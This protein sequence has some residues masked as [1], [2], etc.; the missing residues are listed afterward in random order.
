MLEAVWGFI[1]PY[2]NVIFISAAISAIS[3]LLLRTIDIKAYRTRTWVLFAPLAGSLL[4]AVWI[5]PSCFAHYLAIQSWDL[6]HLI[7]ND[8]SFAYV[9]WIC[10]SWVGLISLSFTGAAAL[11]AISYYHGGA[12][13]QRIYR[14][15]EVTDE[16][17]GPLYDDVLELSER[18]RID[19]PSVYLLESSTPKIFSYGGHGWPKI[20]ISVGL[21]EVLNR[22]ETLAAVGHEIAHIKNNDTLLK[23]A[24]LSL[25][26]AGLF[27][28]V[29]FAV[30]SMLSR[31]REFLADLEGARLTSPIAL[32]MALVKLSAVESEGLNGLILGA[33]SF[34]MFAAKK[35]NWSLF[36]RHPSLDERVKRLLDIA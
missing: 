21:L 27:N 30:D 24:S 35:H 28:I 4:L 12:I 31:D 16:E 11:G 33:L 36:S 13:A 17:L 7:C 3:L 18:A 1:E 9:R 23:S 8:P 34:S 29:G 22:D 10:T 5:S 20:Y 15:D 26:I 2:V 6:I 14:A 25:K 19:E 32:I